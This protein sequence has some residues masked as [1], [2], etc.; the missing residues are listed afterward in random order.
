MPLRLCTPVLIVLYA[1]LNA[2]A[3]LHKPTPSVAA[4]PADA[5]LAFAVL[6]DNRTAVSGEAPPPVYTTLLAQI[7]ASDAQF[8]VNTGDLVLGGTNTA[9]VNL[10]LD[11][12]FAATSALTIPWHVSIGNHD[13][14]AIT[15]QRLKDNRIDPDYHAFDYGNSRFYLLN[16]EIPG[17]EAQIA[18]AQLAWLTQDLRTSGAKAANRFV[19][20]HRPFYSP[21]IDSGKRQWGDA[22]NREA[23]HKL[24]VENRV[25]AVFNGHD[26]LFHQRTVDGVRYVVTGGGGAP[27]YDGADSEKV[28]HFVVVTV[29][30]RQVDIRMVRAQP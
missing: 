12:F 5:T 19:F 25:A 24:F 2:I 4:S 28:H 30:D 3:C 15:L 27:L 20:F 17:Q 13:A 10:E 8:L 23:L 18:G 21:M 9:A 14:D 16:T 26:H 1:L 22:W 6:G 11:A 7:N 29:N